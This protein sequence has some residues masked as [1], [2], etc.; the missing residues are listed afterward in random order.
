MES[1]S[2]QGRSVMMG[3]RKEMMDAVRSAWWGRV[4]SVKGEAETPVIGARCFQSLQ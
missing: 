1:G 2:E 3:I 4:G